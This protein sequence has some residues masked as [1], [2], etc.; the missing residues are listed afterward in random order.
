MLS[1][2]KSAHTMDNDVLVKTV[3]VTSRSE[4]KVITADLQYLVGLV[5]AHL[6]LDIAFI[7]K[8]EQGR[9]VFLQVD[10]KTEDSPI[11]PNNSDPLNQTYCYKITQGEIPE[12][13]N[14]TSANP[15]TRDLA[16]TQALNI[17]SYIG[18]PIRTADGKLYGT[19]CCVGHKVSPLLGERDLAFLKLFAEFA[20]K[21]IDQT[22][23]QNSSSRLIEDKILAI[24]ESLDFE[25]AYQPIYDMCAAKI[26]GYESLSRFPGIPYNS[27]DYWFKEASDV[28]LG[29]I[30]EALTTKK[31]LSQMDQLPEGT[32]LSINAS[33]EYIINGSVERLLKDVPGGRIVLEITEHARITNYDALR[34]ALR[35][36]RARGIRLAID[37]AGAGYASFQHILELSADMIKL[38]ISLI[39]NIDQDPA[40]RALTSAMISF[41]K[42]TGC[43]IIAEGVETA[44][45]LET[46]A[47]IGVC[48][49]QGFYIG[50]P[51]PISKAAEL[52]AIKPPQDHEKT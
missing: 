8:Y 36:L 23:K 5:R 13:I 49:A 1:G 9:R 40:R 19:L 11:K 50:R 18:V 41:A 30:L 33:P 31:A 32:Y 15:I 28:G 38:D 21:Q 45:E 37:D 51:V 6:D 17:K 29:E 22:R 43:E 26:V 42:S 2:S 16:V 46:L 20:G 47:A 27:P 44:E 52:A 24:I 14:D 34:E 39:R 25:I 10:S 48:K 4:E 12:V 3:S 7:A 35:P